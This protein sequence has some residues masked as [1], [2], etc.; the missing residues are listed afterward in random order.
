MVSPHWVIQISAASGLSVLMRGIH[1]LPQNIPTAPLR[2][3]QPPTTTHPPTPAQL[4]G[5]SQIVSYSRTVSCPWVI[6][7]SLSCQIR[8]SSLPPDLSH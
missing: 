3:T 8:V 7:C 1:L 5:R 6:S 2:L 4:A